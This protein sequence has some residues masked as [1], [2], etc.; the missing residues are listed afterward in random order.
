MKKKEDGNM[1][2][3][4]WA[5]VWWGRCKGGRRRRSEKCCWIGDC[6]FCQNSNSNNNYNYNNNNYYNNNNSDNNNSDNNN[7]YNKK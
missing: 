5:D 7:N 4:S 1:R 3:G 2:I 6:D